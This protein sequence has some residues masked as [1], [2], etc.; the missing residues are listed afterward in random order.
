MMTSGRGESGQQSPADAG[1]DGGIW[2]ARPA[3]GRLRPDL[4]VDQLHT[5][6]VTLPETVTDL[7][8]V[9]AAMADQLS[10]FHLMADHDD[11]GRTVLVLTLDCRDLWTTV[12]AAI[13]SVVATGYAPVAVSAQPAQDYEAVQTRS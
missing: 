8:E 5:V 12:L 9:L 6:S 7:P 4:S 10:L 1:P 13:S 3:L 11:H 2:S